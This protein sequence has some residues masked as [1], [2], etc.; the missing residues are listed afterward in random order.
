MVRIAPPVADQPQG[1]TIRGPAFPPDAHRRDPGAF[2]GSRQRGT[3]RR[4]RAV[5]V[6]PGQAQD[7]ASGGRGAACLAASAFLHPFPAL[8]AALI[9]AILPQDRAAAAGMG[10]SCRAGEFREDSLAGIGV[11]GELI[12][13]SGRRAVLSDLR[14]SDEPMIEAQARSWLESFR[15]APLLLRERGPEDRWGRRRIDALVGEA[16][17]VDLAGGLIAA[18]LAYADA[19]EADSLCRSALRG[20]EEAPRAARRGV[21][22]EGTIAATDVARLARRSGRFAVVE[23]RILAIGERPARTYLDFVRRG[24]QGLTVTVQKRTWRSLAEHGLSAATLRGRL[25]RIRG[26]VETGRGP[27]IDLVGAEDIEVVEGER[28]LRR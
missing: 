27:V 7:P 26:M 12:L 18:G 25:V 3:Q 1:P 16:E 6:M 21:W 19:G 23:G 13:S 15:G 14:W 10:A 22:A 11:R 9:G 28:A 20:L 8:L 17:P 2:G 24:E 4:R 5:T